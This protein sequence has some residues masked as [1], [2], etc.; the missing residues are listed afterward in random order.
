MKN[1]TI[2]EIVIGPKITD[3]HVVIRGLDSY[4]IVLLLQLMPTPFELIF[5]K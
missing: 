3:K 5:D 1:A 4:L 2:L